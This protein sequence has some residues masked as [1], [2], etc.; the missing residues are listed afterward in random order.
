MKKI[1]I[2]RNSSVGDIVMALPVAGELKRQFGNDVEITWLVK[3]VYAGLVEN[4]KYIDKVIYFEEFKNRYFRIVK[5]IL[6]NL[7]KK[8]ENSKLDFMKKW[9]KIFPVNKT[10]Q[11][12]KYD[13][14]LDLQGSVES[15]LI[16]LS[17]NADIN[18]IPDFVANG[19]QRFYKQ[20]NI[21]DNTVHRIEEYLN[22]LCAL[23]INIDHQEYL[24]GWS[25][26]SEE[27]SK[28]KSILKEYE[29]TD[30][31]KYVILAL[32]TQWKSK[33]Y[34]IEYWATIIK[35]LNK[36]GKKII[37]IG[38]DSDQKDIDKLIKF[39]L[40]NKF[41]NLCGKTNMR[42]LALLIKNA[43]LVIAGDSGPMHIASS[44]NVPVIALFG[45]TNPEKWGPVSKNSVVLSIDEDC[46]Y[47]YKTR[48]PKNLD[49]LKNI[50]PDIVI[51]EI[52]RY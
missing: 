45:P 51:K 4:N 27:I 37:I 25:F 20:V 43:E 19:I 28:M 10:L 5:E 49:C 30:N 13:I 41:I 11:N 39:G 3:E 6:R 29:L 42:E 44:L 32:T 31:S 2:I 12:K 22:I 46:K 16:A 36:V 47:C 8:I 40:T 26:A 17:A 34:P 18:L 1:L 7:N 52:D 50:K 48:C 35:H 33:N 24:Y 9:L 14:V 15:S 21:K 38:T 23:K